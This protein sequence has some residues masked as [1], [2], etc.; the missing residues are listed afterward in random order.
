VGDLLYTAIV[1]MITFSF[2]AVI[3]VII[4]LSQ[5]EKR[6]VEAEKSYIF[7]LMALD[8]GALIELD[9]SASKARGFIDLTASR[10]IPKRQHAVGRRTF[11]A[12]TE[13]QP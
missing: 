10:R 2:G 8:D 1:F 3:A 13:S 11:T 9:I 12:P 7:A 4:K 5:I 6:M